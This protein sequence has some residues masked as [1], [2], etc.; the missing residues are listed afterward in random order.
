M[1]KKNRVNISV[2][3]KRGQDFFRK[4]MSSTGKKCTTK[5]GVVTC[6]D[7]KEIVKIKI[8]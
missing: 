4:L 6:V 7:R 1:V 2:K 8:R 5:K 3:N